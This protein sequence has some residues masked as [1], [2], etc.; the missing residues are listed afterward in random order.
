MKNLK[1]ILTL[2]LGLWLVQCH[3]QLTLND[4]VKCTQTDR[5]GYIEYLVGKKFNVS[6]VPRWVTKYYYLD[7]ANLVS[8]QKES[9]I[10]VSLDNTCSDV[11]GNETKGLRR[12]SFE[13]RGK[14]FDIYKK[15]EAELKLKYKK[16]RYFLYKGY[17][18]YATEYRINGWWVYIGLIPTTD[19]Q[20]KPTFNSGFIHMYDHMTKYAL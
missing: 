4:L 11:L 8:S 18:V 20:G 14:S 1:Y 17:Q 12:G 15:I 5:D 3:A 2:A 13:F 10:I 16:E 19:L 9:D 7:V 6:S